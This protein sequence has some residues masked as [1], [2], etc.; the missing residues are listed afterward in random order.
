MSVFNFRP[1][2][3][4]AYHQQM[5]VKETKIRVNTY[6]KWQNNFQNTLSDFDGHAVV[7][8]VCS[9]GHITVT[10]TLL[11]VRSIS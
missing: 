5:K 8:C 7:V 9:G 10:R 11:C 6:L 3:W 4:N 2:Y 1:V